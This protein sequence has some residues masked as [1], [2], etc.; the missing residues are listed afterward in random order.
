VAIN[1]GQSMGGETM[2]PLKA[3]TVARKVNKLLNDLAVLRT[4]ITERDV[5]GTRQ[6]FGDLDW[7]LERLSGMADDM[8]DDNTPGD[9]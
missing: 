6:E 9:C 2:A 3:H 8:R 1:E 5:I 4:A 7:E